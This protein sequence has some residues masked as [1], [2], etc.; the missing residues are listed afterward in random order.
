MSNKN[1]NI[2]EAINDLFIIRNDVYSIQWFNGKNQGYNKK[3]EILSNSIINKHLDGQ[4]TI[5]TYAVGKNNNCKWICY[6]FDGD[7]LE[8]EKKKAIDLSK[9]LNKEG[10]ENIIEFSGKKG[11]HVWLFFQETDSYSAYKFGRNICNGHVVHEI[12]P[13]QFELTQDK[14]YGNLVKMPLGIHRVVDKRSVLLHPITYELM[15][16]EDSKNFLQSFSN[17]ERKIIPKYEKEKVESH[18]VKYSNPIVKKEMDEDT[19][20]MIN[21]G[22]SAGKRH[23]TC[24]G[25][26]KDLYNKG[27]NKEEVTKEALKFNS[28]CNPPKEDSMIIGHVNRLFDKKDDYLKKPDFDMES[29]KKEFERVLEKEKIR[30]EQ[31]KLSKEKRREFG[32]PEEKIPFDQK[33]FYYNCAKILLRHITFKTTKDNEEVYYYNDNKGIYENFKKK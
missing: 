10:Y 32:L 6:D 21:M 31:N 9:H 20:R 26:I 18:E 16:F 1:T 7:N 30:Q 29:I 23:P 11:Y 4:Q 27:W 12:F 2:I 28:N 15:S 13:K 24:F 25:I 14:P 8:E 5:G 33:G 3:D 17:R 19:Q 22:S